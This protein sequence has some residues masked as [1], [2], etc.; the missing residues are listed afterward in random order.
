MNGATAAVELLERAIGYT[1]GAL[2]GV[3]PGLLRHPTPCPRWDLGDLLAHMADSLDALTEASSGYLP[4]A[5]APASPGDPVETLRVKACALLGAWTSPA[6]STV[7]VGGRRLDARLLLH[8]G[9]LEIVL[10]GWD[11]GQATGAAPAIPERLAEALLPAARSLVTD[12][13]RG[14]RFA[15]AMPC[16]EAEAWSVHLLAFCG[17]ASL[18]QH[19]SQPEPG[20]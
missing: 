18:E 1:R 11:V 17:R 13:D 5:P 3:T 9:A 15:V 10:H 19:S 8:A 12:A 4:L 14:S 20:K 16:D 7:L 2:A 6:A